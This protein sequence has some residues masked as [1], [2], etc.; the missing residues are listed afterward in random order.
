VILLDTHI[1]FVYINDGPEHL[2]T[3]ANTAIR[4]HDVLGVSIISCW[5]IAMLVAKQRIKLSIDVQDWISQA[6]AYKGIKLIELTPEIATL[7]TRLPGTFHKDPADRML[8][9]TCL[10]LGIPLLTLD[11]NI[12]AWGYIP[13]IS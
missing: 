13:T 11:R 6:L 5:E 7:S 12:I 2:S 4:A 8:A 10:K 9:A 3:E 1:W